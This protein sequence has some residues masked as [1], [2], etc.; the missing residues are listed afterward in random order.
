MRRDVHP[1]VHLLIVC[2]MLPMAGCTEFDLLNATIPC[3]GYSRTSDLKYGELP[4]QKLDVYR[5][6]GKPAAAPV[7]IFFYGGDWQSGNKSDYRFV[8]DAFT[9]RGFVA[10]LPDYRLYPQ[11]TFPSFVEDA[12]LAVRWTHDN[13]ANFGGDPRRI[14]LMGHSA[15]AHIAAL[16]TLDEHY[17]KNVG[18]DRSA[19]RATA[20]LSGPY[21]FVPAPYDR[22]PFGMT[23]NDTIPDP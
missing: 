14:Y 9:S 20:G 19:I 3:W 22:P 6:R 8:A 15:G 13:A 17:L 2:L 16:L 11:V 21:D 7:V 18:L 12:A 4:R 1:L 10:V 5:P 23:A